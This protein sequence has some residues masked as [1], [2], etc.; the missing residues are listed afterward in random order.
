MPIHDWGRIPSGL[1]H[2]FHQVWTAEIAKCLNRGLLPKGMSALVEQRVGPKEGDVLGIERWKKDALPQARGGALILEP[3]VTKI[4]QRNTKE[5]YAARANRVAVRHRLGQIIAVIEIVSPGNKDSRS[6]LRDF[7]DKSVDLLRLGVHLLVIDLFPP[8]K[9]DPSGIHKAIW[10]EVTEEDFTFPAGKNLIL[11]SYEAGPTLTAY[12][13]PVAVGDSLPDVALFLAPGTHVKVPL[14]ST[15][16]ATWD[17]SPEDFRTAIETGV[18]PDP[19]A[20]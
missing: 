15:Y 3:P 4:V 8:T 20:E 11:A 17:A 18:I 6:A 19:D 5:I 9:R 14:E 12:V 2:H 7:V 1:F 16:Q 13:E 10:D